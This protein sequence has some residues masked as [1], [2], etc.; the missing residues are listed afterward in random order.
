MSLQE[1]AGVVLDRVAEGVKL[2][3]AAKETG[4]AHGV[5]ASEVYDAALLR[6]RAERS[7]GTV[8]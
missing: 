8:D 7:A 2:K 6:R 4:A 5:P 1:L 3:T